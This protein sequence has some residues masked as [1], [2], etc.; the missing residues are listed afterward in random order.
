MIRLIDIL[1]EAL[2]ELA[3]TNKSFH[4]YKGG[5]SVEKDDDEYSHGTIMYDFKTDNDLE[6]EVYLS[7]LS[8]N[9]DLYEFT[10][11]DG[12]VVDIQFSAEG[13]YHATNNP[14]E[15][16]P[17]MATIMKCAKDAL[18]KHPFMYIVYAPS[19]TKGGGKKDPKGETQRTKLYDYYI[20]K[21]FPGSHTKVLHNGIVVTKLSK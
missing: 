12:Q 9:D 18:S 21:D 5:D 13:G 15:L 11:H 19:N 7:Y 17:I 20:K 6:Y 8:P 4:Y 2:T 3:D 16:F 1:K 10:D 14:K